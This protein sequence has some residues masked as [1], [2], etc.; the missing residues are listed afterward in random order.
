MNIQPTDAA[1]KRGASFDKELCAV[2]FN[3]QFHTPVTARFYGNRCTVWVY[4][5]GISC[6]GTYLAT[7]GGYDRQYAGLKN[8][9]SNAGVI[10]SRDELHELS[11][12]ELMM[13]AVA[14]YLY[15]GHPVYVH[16]AHP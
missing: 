3:G 13:T 7:G 10:F 6:Q 11:N 8:A 2:V 14:S 4:G 16:S 9:L 12:C 5:N 1:I 15:P